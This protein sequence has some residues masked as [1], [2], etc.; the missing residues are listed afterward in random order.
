MP[1]GKDSPG[2]LGDPCLCVY[3]RTFDKPSDSPAPLAVLKPLGAQGGLLAP[4]EVA[5]NA[6]QSR[7]QDEPTERGGGT[8]VAH[9]FFQLKEMACKGTF[10]SLP[11]RGRSAKTGARVEELWKPVQMS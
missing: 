11:W 9:P 3:A 6:I 7:E 5:C 1:I 10:P 2:W 4:S 8:P